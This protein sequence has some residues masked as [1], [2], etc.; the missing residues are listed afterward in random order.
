MDAANIPGRMGSVEPGELSSYRS[1]Q[2]A[3]AIEEKELG[4]VEGRNSQA[5]GCDA[6]GKGGAGRSINSW[7]M[8]E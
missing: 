1:L 6:C 5:H 4:Q 3:N 8:G 2:G 7:V